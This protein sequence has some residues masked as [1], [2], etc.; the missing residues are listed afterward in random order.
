SWTHRHLS[1]YTHLELEL[2]F[3]SFEELL[4]HIKELVGGFFFFKKKTFDLTAVNLSCFHDVLF[5]ILIFD[6]S[7]C[8][9][10]ALLWKL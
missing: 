6:F 7:V 8:Y 3:I 4:A 5:L 1:E 2:G 10:S 9:R